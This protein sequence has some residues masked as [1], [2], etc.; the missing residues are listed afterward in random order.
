MA[1]GIP[2]VVDRGAFGDL[3]T[4]IVEIVLTDDYAAGGDAVT[5]AELGFG[6][7]GVIKGVFSSPMLSSD[8]SKYVQVVYVD[9]S[10]LTIDMSTGVEVAD[11]TDLS[12]LTASLLVL[13]QGQG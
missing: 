9:G 2:T 13:G 1:Q 6:T 8:L 5:V 4:R 12:D 11:S 10:I 3:F 7:N